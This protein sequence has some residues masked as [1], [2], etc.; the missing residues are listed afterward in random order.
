M[1]ILDLVGEDEVDDDGDGPG[2]IRLMRSTSPQIKKPFFSEPPP[3]SVTDTLYVA[4]EQLPPTTLEEPEV[5]TTQVSEEPIP[6]TPASEPPS[7]W[8]EV[9]RRG[10]PVNGLNVSKVCWDA[11]KEWHLRVANGNKPRTGE[12][13]MEVR[14]FSTV[15]YGSD[16]YTRYDHEVWTKKDITYLN[17]PCPDPYMPPPEK[18]V[19]L[20]IRICDMV[21]GKRT[22]KLIGVHDILSYNVTGFFVVCYLVESLGWSVHRAIDAFSVSRPPGIYSCFMLDSLFSRFNETMP[23]NYKYPEPPAWDFEYAE[24]RKQKRAETS[25][26]FKVP[27]LPVSKKRLQVD[28][29][30]LT[31]SKH[32]KTSLDSPQTSPVSSPQSP[33]NN[34]VGLPVKS[35]HLER[36]L[37]RLCSLLEKDYESTVMLPL[38]LKEWVG[39][40]GQL[41]LLKEMNYFATWKT[42]GNP[43]T[44]MIINEGVFLFSQTGDLTNVKVTFPA[45]GGG[46]PP[47]NLNN[48]VIQG[49][50]V[51]DIDH[52]NKTQRFLI[53]DILVLEGKVLYKQVP[54]LRRHEMGNATLIQ[55]R[56]VHQA[57]TRND[58]FR[59]RLKSYVPVFSDPPK[60][61]E[62]Q[63]TAKFAS[64]V[65][66][67][68]PSLPHSWDGIVFVPDLAG[69]DNPVLS[70]TIGDQE[71]KT[72]EE[73]ITALSAL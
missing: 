58:M 31:A 61:K 26:A 20:F 11:D 6:Q 36:L 17:Y 63:R 23:L 15:I 71:W 46:Q 47:Q 1:N 4:P 54:F 35:P 70:W 39:L 57:L 28:S 8:T 55:P 33:N 24:I 49:E 5:P 19:N 3:P 48:T 14:N 7:H 50:L 32:A 10:Q 67:L 13:V 9:S 34:R 43:Y 37:E 53:T 68:M 18:Y 64:M 65:R 29:E 73:L 45:P 12:R 66:E 59:V 42:Q 2:R 21:F 22:G 16:L 69:T 38:Y 40:T 72:A 44:M 41:S 25:S 30:S 27:S 52:G 56:N 60:D 51:I 62:G